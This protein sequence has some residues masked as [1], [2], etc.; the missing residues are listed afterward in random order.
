[1]RTGSHRAVPF[2]GPSIMTP[3]YY[4]FSPEEHR[5]QAVLALLR[6][7]T[8]SH[9]STAFDICR[10]DLYKFRNRGLMVVR[11]ALKDH[12]RGLKQPHNRLGSE[13]EQ[14]VM[15]LC[16]RYPTHSS[17]HVRE[18]L[19]P[20]APCAR[21]IQCIRARNH[22]ARLPTRAPPSTPARRIP[23]QVIERVR[24]IPKL[25]PHLG[26]ERVV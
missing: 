19:G 8:A 17:Y 13:Q 25:R 22:M 23:E 14:K 2:L 9:V 7:E 21:T 26:P 10:S 18:K 16:Q 11:A 24:Y 6:G 12:L 1:M 20:N 15:A 4:E 5:L 3:S